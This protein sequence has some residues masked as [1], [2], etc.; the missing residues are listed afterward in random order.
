MEVVA[1]VWK[2][3]LIWTWLAPRRSKSLPECA[4]CTGVLA[5]F[6]RECCLYTILGT[7]YS[8]KLFVGLISDAST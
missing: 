7:A 1:N 4:N 2:S 8:T 3:W 6:E 5:F